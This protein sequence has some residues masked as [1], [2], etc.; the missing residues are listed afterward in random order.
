MTDFIFKLFKIRYHNQNLS[1]S[2]IRLRK[3]KLSGEI[4]K[5]EILNF[6]DN[7]GLIKKVKIICI[8]KKLFFHL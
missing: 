7:F 2:A 3:E 1:K 5:N 4:N 6:F 8:W